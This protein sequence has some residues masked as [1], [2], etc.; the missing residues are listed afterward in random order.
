MF[1]STLVLLSISVSTR[2]SAYASF[3]LSTRRN[4]E[5]PTGVGRVRGDEVAA[6][7]ERALPRS[8]DGP[9]EPLTNGNHRIPHTVSRTDPAAGCWRGVTDIV[10]SVGKGRDAFLTGDDEKVDNALPVRPL[11]RSTRRRTS[12]GKPLGQE[13]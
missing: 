7:A 4:G 13:I 12:L 6:R 2:A 5:D 8:L 1:D 9:R 10:R 3:Q 11:G